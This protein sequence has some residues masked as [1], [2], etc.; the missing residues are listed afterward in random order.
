MITVDGDA[1]KRSLEFLKAGI[2][3]AEILALRSAVKV[4]ED[5]AKGTNLFRDVTGGTRR[6]IHGTVF[7]LTGTVTAGGAAQFIENGTKPHIIA[8]RNAQTLRFVVNGSVIFRRTVHHPGT[9]GRPFMHQA[10]ERGAIAA[11]YAAEYFV[12]AAIRGV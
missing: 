10:R 9:S 2:R 8:A 6:S 5:A 1:T 4:T 3:Q 7:G 11:T 12:E